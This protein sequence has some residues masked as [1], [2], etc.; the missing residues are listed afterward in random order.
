MKTLLNNSLIIILAMLVLLA[1]TNCKKKQIKQ[2][3]KPIVQQPAP[4]GVME[5]KYKWY[6]GDSATADLVLTTHVLNCGY[7]NPQYYDYYTYN[8]FIPQ[9]NIQSNYINYPAGTK[10]DTLIYY[11]QNMKIFKY[12]RYY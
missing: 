4:I 3:V 7:C 2:P 12:V 11:T 10:K 1:C 5:G 6:A 8:L 9:Y